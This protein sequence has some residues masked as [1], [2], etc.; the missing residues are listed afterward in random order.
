MLFLY[1]LVPH[2]RRHGPRGYEDFDSYKPWLRDEFSFR[3]VY[4]LCR[5]IWFPDGQAYFS[6]DHLKAQSRAPGRRTDYENLVYACCQ[7]NACKQNAELPLT[8]DDSSWAEHLRVQPDGRIEGLTLQGRRLIAIC[9]LDRPLLV[10]S[11]ARLQR[12]LASATGRESPRLRALLEE[13]QRFPTDL[14]DLSKLRPPEGNARPEGIGASYFES[15][16]R[17]ELPKTSG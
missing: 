3:C 1:P 14:P 12:L 5:E 11:R 16:R 13:L 6:V 9:R 4:C 2:Q 15:R 10:E 17:G 7:C 8:P